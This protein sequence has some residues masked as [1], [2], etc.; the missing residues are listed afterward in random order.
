MTAGPTLGLALSSEEH[1]PAKLVDTAV[2]AERA[3]F[4]FTL[5]SDHYHP[6]VPSQGQS[7]FV[8]T[9][10]GAM[11]TR[12]STMTLGTGVTC[13]IIRTHP[14]VIAQAAA[15]TAALS[16]DRFW[17]GLGT[18]ER[19]N[20]HVIGAPW[21]PAD[22]RQEML[23]EAVVVIRRLWTGEEVDHRGRHFTVENARLYTRPSEPPPIM[24]AAGG[25]VA[26]ES[27]GRIGD[28]LI[29]TA[30]EAE[31]IEKY[32]SAAE[33]EPG[34]RIGQL[35]VCWAASEKEA[36]ATARQWWPN[37]AI[38][39]A[40]SQELARPEDF[41]DLTRDAT[42]DQIAESVVCGPDP[43]KYLAAIGGFAKAGFDHVY[44]HQIGPDQAGFIGFAKTHLL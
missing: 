8:W 17:L 42:E 18:G 1:E 9:I 35:S 12:T 25:P 28:G 6:W 19:L 13:P 41:D 34:P 37:A 16:G 31:L 11:A 39:G 15:T 33:S 3:G 38:H 20:E 24:V 30:P 2:A 36:R 29:S 43:Q 7:P 27:A 14:A 22:V 5:V 23:E 26:A 32:E 21:P 44:L 40:A 10:L 4:S